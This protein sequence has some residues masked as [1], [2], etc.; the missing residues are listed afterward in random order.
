MPT[1]LEHCT[2]NTATC[3]LLSPSDHNNSMQLLRLRQVQT[4]KQFASIIVWVE[5]TQQSVNLIVL[6]RANQYVHLQL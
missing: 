5:T 6:A 4:Q 2:E 1:K 3:M